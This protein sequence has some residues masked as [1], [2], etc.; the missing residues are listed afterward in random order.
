MKTIIV[1]EVLDSTKAI[2]ADSGEKLLNTTLSALKTNDKIIIDFSNI[3]QYTTM[4]FNAFVAN[5]IINHMSQKDYA[6]K[7]NLIGLSPL[8]QAT[9][10]KSYK[11]AL[12]Y[13]KEQASTMNSIISNIE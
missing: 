4:F 6:R 10:E 7:I 8:G 13:D 2:S 1:S 5:M 11:N 3:R 9:Y 12:N